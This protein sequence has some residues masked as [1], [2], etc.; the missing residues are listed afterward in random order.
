MMGDE[1]LTLLMNTYDAVVRRHEI[2][3]SVFGSI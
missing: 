2:F 3:R 1:K